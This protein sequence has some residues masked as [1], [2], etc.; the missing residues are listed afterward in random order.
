ME[1]DPILIRI[2]ALDE[3]TQVINK[4]SASLKR[5][6]VRVPEMQIGKGLTQYTKINTI[7]PQTT[8]SLGSLNEAL[9]EAGISQN[10]FSNYLR[11]NNMQLVEGVG[12][13]DKLTGKVISQ[14]QAVK[15]A[16]IQSRRFNFAWLS[17]MFA[18]MAL[19]RVFGGLI[20]SQMQLWGV[21]DLMSAAWTLVMLPVMEAITP[22]LYKLIDAFMNLPD[23]VKLAIGFAVLFM[24]VLGM[25]LMV[26]G[27]IMLFFMGL[28]LLA[29]ALFGKLVAGAGAFFAS[30]GPILLIIG[31][32]ILIIVAVW[33]AWKSN[34]MN[35]RENIKNWIAGIKQWFNG[36]LTF[37]KGILNI[38][39]GIFTG[40]FDLVRRGIIQI[41][42]SIGMQLMGIFKVIVNGIV[43]IF[44]GGL[45][46]VYNFIKVIID[47]V[48]WIAGKVSKFFGGREFKWRMPSFQAGGVM[49][50]TG[51]AYLHA[52]E[53]IIPR[54]E[55][56]STEIVF[57]PSV[58]INAE[59]SS[60]YDLR[61]LADKLNKYWAD[62]FQRAI[63]GRSK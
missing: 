58:T 28:K 5:L 21:S 3:A 41:F 15:L 24:G 2:Q 30:L 20:R 36:L 63:K 17:I 34:F 7:I 14:G 54:N 8:Q 45:K 39:R 29:P 27:Q 22:L 10:Y 26:G 37:F 44:K 38:I 56:G 6:E 25:I 60:D 61:E 46:L 52:G 23:G 1:T 13:L 47:G 50:Y 57:S 33:L 19:N 43:I 12:V 62:D 18:G 53:K 4:V 31:A 51:V 59:I 49:P 11:R 32:I 48:V 55:T 16:T 35:I 40:N 9:K 42:K